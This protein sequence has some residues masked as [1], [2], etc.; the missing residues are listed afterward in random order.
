MGIERVPFA[1]DTD[2]WDTMRSVV[3]IVGIN[4][5]RRIIVMKKKILE[6]NILYL[7]III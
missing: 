5:W 1:Q 7:Q 2:G 4:P 6:S 3:E